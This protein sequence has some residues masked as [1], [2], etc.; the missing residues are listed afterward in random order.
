MKLKTC[1]TCQ[2]WYESSVFSTHPIHR[3]LCSKQASFKKPDDFCSSWVRTRTNILC[4][5]LNKVVPIRVCKELSHPNCQICPYRD[6]LLSVENDYILNRSE[7]RPINIIYKQ[8]VTM[9]FVDGRDKIHK[10]W[11]ELQNSG[12]L[13]DQYNP[14][15]IL[16]ATGETL[17]HLVET[18]L[19]A[20]ESIPLSLENRIPPYVVQVYN[21]IVDG[22][23]EF[24]DRIVGGKAIIVSDGTY[25]F[26]RRNIEGLKW[27]K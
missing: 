6:L 4:P 16:T 23:I 13:T 8:E 1:R 27:N 12:L 18:F 19:D 20:V 26:R 10:A 24:L 5:D 17:L 22:K 3:R 2:F 7:R 9:G 15:E 21:E 14:D 25:S 11:V